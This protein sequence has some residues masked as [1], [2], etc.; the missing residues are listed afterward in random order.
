[1][2]TF[3]GGQ[4][5]ANGRRTGLGSGFGGVIAYL[6]EGRR[7]E[8]E[9]AADAAERVAWTDTRNLLVEDPD[10]VAFFMRAWADQNPR[11]KKPVYHF[12]AALAPD[13]HLSRDQWGRVADRLLE[14]LGLEEHQAFIAL[15]TDCDHQHIHI[16]VNRVGPDGRAWKPSYDALKQQAAAR[17]LERDLG[18]RIVPTKR[19]QRLEQRQ[20]SGAGSERREI[21]KPFAQRVA[22]VALEDLRQSWSWE[23]LEDRLARHGLR[24][25]PAKRGGGV[26][27]T[28]GHERAGAARIDRSLSGPRLA[29][30]YG[31]P[32][33]AYRKR[34]PDRPPL[35][36]AFA[37]PDVSADLPIEDRAQNVLRQIA[38]KRAT[39]SEADV[40]RL[41]DRDLDGDALL[42]HVLE[43]ER[44]VSVGKDHRGVDRFASADYLAGEERMF[45]ASDRLAGRR[46]HQLAPDR[47]GAL[48]EERFTHLSHEQR[49]A[50]LHATT[51]QDLALIVGRAGAGKTR[52]TRA[53][54]GAYR[55]AG[56]E[57]RGA[58]L[59]G[60]AAEGLATEAGIE[61]RTLAS[62]ELG[63]REGRGDLSPRDVL[64]IDEA[65]M[66]D[67]RQMRRV[68]EHVQERGAKVVLIGDPDQLKAIGAGDAF[69]GLIEQHGAARVDT[70]RRQAESWQREASEQLADGH[71]EPALSAYAEHGAIQWHTGPA[72]ARDA[73]VMRYFE[74]RYLTPD[75]SCVI[76]THRKADV[77]RLNEQIR[78]VRRAAGELGPAVRLNGRELA[79][80]DRVLF[81]RNDPTGRQVRT[82]DGEGRGVKN[83]ALGTL[84]E[85]EPHRLRIRLD[86]GRTI[87]LDPRIYDRL[88]HGYAVTVHKA[89]GVTVDRA[90][91]L[92]D[93]GFD[94]NLSYVALT[95]HRHQLALYVD[96]ETFAS[97]EQ[98]RHVFAHEPRKDLVRDY[99]P[100]GD[101]GQILEPES[102]EPARESWLPSFESVDRELTPER[103]E[104]LRGAFDE[105]ER[106]DEIEIQ[107]AAAM[108]SRHA[109][110]YKGSLPDLDREI[111]ELEQMPRH[112]DHDLSRVY[113]RPEAARVALEQ[114]TRDRGPVEAFERL[115][116]TPEDF[117]RLHGRQI[118]GRPGRARAEA[119]DTARQAG[120]KGVKR[121]ELAAQLRGDYQTADRYRLE[122]LALSKER[123][124]LAPDR[125]ALVEEL[126]V[127]AAGLQLAQLEGRLE[128]DHLKTLR[129]LQQSDA[130]RLRP[131][132]EALGAFHRAHK[133]GTRP[134]TLW[135][136]ARNLSNLYRT[137]PRS[138][139]QR[140]MPPQLRLL[141]SAVTAA[142]AIVRKL[143]PEY[144]EAEV[145]RSI[146]RP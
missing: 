75:Q 5:L 82:V 40:R 100:S 68:L 52:L 110:P 73:L 33:R 78:E 76:L 16:A 116:E 21:E 141:A 44:V 34:R 20:A 24:L 131:L 81:Q 62:Y 64:L 36:R 130:V 17:E 63:W 125:G 56:Y 69:R 38:G 83:G 15:H 14:R 112:F 1:M 31:E 120:S 3:R 32:F 80:G 18:L 129:D 53:V 139:L 108:R 54:A 102:L 99:R 61:A 48:L 88:T 59:A 70:I 137:T 72:Q 86:S 67:V 43:S 89:Q 4:Q 46:G 92:A 28:D 45:T 85:A 145:R 90:Y 7:E 41:T 115:K 135:R 138:L 126:R 95:R 97:G 143:A 144:E 140:L 128:P 39:W 51:A 42:R 93:R 23:E 133:T 96:R 101:L 123:D 57:V 79:A 71:L 132:Q 26:N 47:V 98:L 84:I 136:L 146:L 122:N 25:E 49:D 114:L 105:L 55:E 22:A 2:I 107:K 60:K 35:E 91:V 10:H 11:V 37:R 19:D 12:G 6:M 118:L 121:Y 9:L 104:R 87:E 127:Q 134:V 113:R 8:L 94:R 124:A 77:R 58:A 66:I 29:D 30:R 50:V 27:V 74:D 106:W 142:A 119:L 65:G 103:L 13:E 109:L 117:G 111:Y